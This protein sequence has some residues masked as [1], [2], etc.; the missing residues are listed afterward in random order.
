MFTIITLP[1]VIVPLLDTGLLLGLSHSI[2][3]DPMVPFNMAVQV[4]FSECPAVGAPASRTKVTLREPR[5][6]NNIHISV[7]TSHVILLC[8]VELVSLEVL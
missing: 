6:Q 7:N 5:K 4:R 8:S 3:G 2:V 1:T